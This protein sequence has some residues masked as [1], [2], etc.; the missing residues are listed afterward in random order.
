MSF[1]QGYGLYSAGFCSRA[2]KNLSA[3][4]LR[5]MSQ[6]GKCKTTEVSWY[7]LDKN[8]DF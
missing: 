6:M 7:W 8:V 1:S 5:M 4:S 2:G 3:L